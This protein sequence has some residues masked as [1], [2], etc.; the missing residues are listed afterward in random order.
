M[1]V[2]LGEGYEGAGLDDLQAAM[3]MCYGGFGMLWN[4]LG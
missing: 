3:G 2:F 4:S 1:K